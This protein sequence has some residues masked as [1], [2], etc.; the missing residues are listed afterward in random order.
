MEGT[1]RLLLL[2]RISDANISVMLSSTVKEVR[3]A[4]VLISSHG[5]DKW[6][7]TETV[8]LAMGSR[9]NQALLEAVKGRFPEV[10]PIGDCLEPRKAKE[11]IH[12]GF[13]A[14]LRICS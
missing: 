7:D 14:G 6:L 3:G 13:R 5:E 8:V 9:P 12:E 2:K 10:I 1:T 4:R 11:A